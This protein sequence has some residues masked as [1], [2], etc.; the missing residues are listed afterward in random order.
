MN[1]EAVRSLAYGVYLLSARDGS[2][3]NGCIV[4]TVAQVCE[5]PLRILIGVN[6]G[7]KTCEMVSKT[8]KF[9]VSVFT[10]SAPK[11]TIAHFGFVSGEDK[12]KFEDNAIYER[13]SNG[14]CYLN[15]YCNSYLSCNVVD[16]R[17]LGSHK[18]FLAEVEESRIFNNEETLTYAD[19]K[20]G[21]YGN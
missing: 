17:V 7:S 12:N 10:K 11:E 14:I 5:E 19:Y 6:N 20:K 16:E 8:K 18:I 13:S 4:N 9:N 21:R 3:D 1:S 15:M 2:F